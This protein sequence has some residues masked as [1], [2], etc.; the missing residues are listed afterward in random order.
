[1]QT[2]H[3]DSSTAAADTRRASPS[4]SPTAAQIHIDTIEEVKQRADIIE[5]ISE[6]VALKKTGKEYMGLCPFHDEKTPSFSVS[7]TKQAYYC[8]GCSTGGNTIKFLMDHLGLKF[9]DAVCQLAQQFSISVRYEDGTR[10]NPTRN[11]SDSLPHSQPRKKAIDAVTKEVKPEKEL[12]VDD[13]YIRRSHERLFHPGAV[14][15]QAL[16]WLTGSAR[17]FSDQM[18]AHYRLGLE[19][20]RYKNEHSGQWEK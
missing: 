19:S 20:V 5:V 2:K 17:N 18:I 7:P 14:Q 4:T 12:T 16:G 8:H 11:L 10:D 6:Y 15:E 3:Q 9:S 1:M 13:A